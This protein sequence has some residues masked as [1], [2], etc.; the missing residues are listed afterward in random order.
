MHLACLLHMLT[1]GEMPKLWPDIRQGRRAYTFFPYT[2]IAYLFFYM[3]YLLGLISWILNSRFL[4]LW[5][6]QLPAL[7]RVLLLSKERCSMC[8]TYI[9]GRQT[10]WD[11]YSPRDVDELDLSGRSILEL[12]EVIQSIYPIRF[13]LLQSWTFVLGRFRCYIITAPEFGCWEE[14]EKES[15]SQNFFDEALLAPLPIPGLFIFAMFILVL[16][17]HVV[18]YSILR[19][20]FCLC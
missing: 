19:I 5:C 9:E 20:T 7:D 14:L 16:C 8:A 1:Y 13:I 11:D 6:C 15:E 2:M 3:F 10:I 17:Y 12:I 18:L 4:V